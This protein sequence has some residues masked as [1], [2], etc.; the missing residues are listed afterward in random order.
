MF[1]I[2]TSFFAAH[3]ETNK[4]ALSAFT[5]KSGPDTT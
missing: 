4:A 1:V 2:L 5:R 3:D